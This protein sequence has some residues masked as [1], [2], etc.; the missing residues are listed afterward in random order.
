MTNQQRQTEAEAIATAEGYAIREHSDDWSF[1]TLD[2]GQE[3]VH[4][5]VMGTK[6]IRTHFELVHDRFE[7][8]VS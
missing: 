6:T 7:G 4:H 1:F 5:R 3:V 2:D 8:F